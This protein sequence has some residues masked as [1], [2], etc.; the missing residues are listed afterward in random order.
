MFDSAVRIF[1]GFI[2]DDPG[3]FKG[4]LRF[5]LGE[6]PKEFAMPC[7]GTPPFVRGEYI[8]VAATESLISGADYTALAYRRLGVNGATHPASWLTP[9]IFVLLGACTPLLQ[10]LEPVRDHATEAI[11]V[12]MV[13][14][15]IVGAIRIWYI[16]QALKMLSNFKPPLTTRSSGR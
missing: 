14:A 9:A 12:G 13:C 15:G 3:G 6:P 11:V 8:A 1:T 10:R 2:S 5:A 4:Y 16:R 7:F